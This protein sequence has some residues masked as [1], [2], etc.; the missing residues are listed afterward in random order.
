MAP[1]TWTFHWEN[2][3]RN[4]RLSL[5]CNLP[6]QRYA[7]EIPK[8]AAGRRAISK[9]P[10]APLPMRPSLD[11][12]R[13]S[14]PSPWTWNDLFAGFE[15]LH[16]IP[17]WSQYPGPAAAIGKTGPGHP[18][19]FRGQVRTVSGLNDEGY[20]PQGIHEA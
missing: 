6:I 11:L 4:L 17:A 1:C 16:P 12:R 10:T 5:C 2:R 9:P 13:E 20:L 18:L 7:W 19:V 14:F 8:N 15:R 3:S